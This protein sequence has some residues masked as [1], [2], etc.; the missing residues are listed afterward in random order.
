MSDA[1]APRKPAGRGGR[2]LELPEH[3]KAYKGVWVFIEHDRGSVHQVSWELLGEGRMLAD[4]LGVALSGV[5]LGGPDDN[6]TA[7]AN[8]AFTH[9]AEACYTVRDAV[10]DGYRNEPFTR[11]LTDLVNKY[12]PEIVLLGATTMG[13]D[14]AGS[15]ATTLQTGLTA[16]CTELKI[17]PTSRALAA[18]RPTFGGSLLCTIM[19]LAY[20]PQMATVRPRVMAMPKADTKRSGAIIED[21]LGM[22]ETDIV[23]KLLDFIPDA[24]TSKVNLAYAD[25]IVS[26]GKG[27]KNP[28]NFKLIW[29]LAKTLGGDVGATR[30]VVQSGWVAAERQVGQTGKTVRPK[31]YIAAGISGAIQHR[32]GMEA[33]DVIVAINNDPNAPIFDFAHFGIVGN[34]MTIL[35][36][37]TEAF[38]NHFAIRR[39]KAA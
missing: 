36:A 32:V 7:F 9:G 38:R 3:L 35:P 19:T 33:A 8:E 17:D 4:T 21:T 5:L 25:V 28:E 18:T 31:L 12:R 24:N 15:V 23:T 2:N 6:L 27:L 34:A 20:R 10:L 37:L 16:D 39:M 26:G 14:L 29:D 11:G 30:P 13:R 22:V 1:P